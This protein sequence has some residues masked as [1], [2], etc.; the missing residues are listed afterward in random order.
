MS[1]KTL[2][3]TGTMKQS[4]H[5]RVTPQK[6]ECP[7]ASETNCVCMAGGQGEC[8][9]GGCCQNS[10]DGCPDLAKYCCSKG[11]IGRPKIYSNGYRFEYTSPI[12]EYGQSAKKLCQL[13][14]NLRPPVF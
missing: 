7:Y 3:D 9:L 2:G 5:F 13:T 14:P 8:T 10:K 11:M 12:L 6:N 1:Y 4:F